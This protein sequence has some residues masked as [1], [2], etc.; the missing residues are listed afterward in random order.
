MDHV[1]I[2]FY[3]RIYSDLPGLGGEMKKE[4]RRMQNE[5]RTSRLRQLPSSPGFDVTSRRGKQR[6]LLLDRAPAWPGWALLVVVGFIGLM[7]YWIGVEWDAWGAYRPA[8]LP[9]GKGVVG[10]L[11]NFRTPGQ[12]GDSFRRAGKPGSTAGRETCR[13]EALAV[14]RQWCG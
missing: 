11:A 8:S 7:E 10:W 6:V 14:A 12:A 9:S 3:G 4:E 5:E 2:F 13:H 1:F